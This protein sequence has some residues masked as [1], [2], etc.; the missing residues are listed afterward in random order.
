MGR[1][2]EPRKKL[3]V[4]ADAVRNAEGRIEASQGP[5]AERPPGSESRARSRGFPRNLGGPV[6]SAED[7]RGRRG[8]PVIHTRPLALVACRQIGAN[9]QATQAV[10]PSEGNEA[11]REGRQEV[12]AP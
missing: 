9:R 1:G 2:I 3:T 10:P 8:V 11:R 12:I 4:V 5:D 6:V 7:V